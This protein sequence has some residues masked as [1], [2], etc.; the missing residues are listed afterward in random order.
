M[1]DKLTR[2]LVTFVV[3]WAVLATFVIL[4]AQSVLVLSWKLSWL[5]L[6]FWDILYFLL[7]AVVGVPPHTHTRAR[8]LVTPTTCVQICKLWA[9]S[10]STFQLAVYSQPAGGDVIDVCTPPNLLCGVTR[11]SPPPHARTL[12]AG[13]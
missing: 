4:A 11:L 8:A 2:V 10:E 7:L 1:Y 5:V 13:P 12:A 3:A 9:P 6:R